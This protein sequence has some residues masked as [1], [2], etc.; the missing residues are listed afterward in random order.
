M[1]QANVDLREIPIPDFGLPK[2]KPQVS[3]AEYESRIEAARR[4]AKADGLAFLVVYGDREHFA[5]L[6]FLTGYDPRF[7]ESL[8]VIPVSGSG[9]PTLVVGNEGDGYAQLQCPGIRRLLYQGFSLLG[10]PRDRSPRLDEVFRSCGIAAGSRVGL[11][12]WK[13][14][15][16]EEAADPAHWLDAPAFIAD[17]LRA[18][19][20]DAA[21]VTN[22]TGIFMNAVDGLRLTSSAGQL[23]AFEFGAAHCSQS[24]RDLIAGLRPGMSELEAV[25]LMHLNGLPLTAHLMFSAGYR[26]RFG[27]PSPSDRVI[28]RGDPFTVAFGLEGGLTCRAGFVAAG[29]SELP[30]ESREY[31]EQMVK[32]YF[33]AAVAWYEAIGVGV[34]GGEVCSAVTAALGGLKLTLNPGHYVHL[35]EWVHTPFFPGS[36]IPLRSGMMLQSDMIPFW[37]PQ[38]H[39]SNIE[40]TIALAD[41]PLRQ[42]IETAHPGTWRRISARRDFVQQVLGI[43]LRPE[44]LPFSNLQCVLQPFALSPGRAM[45]VL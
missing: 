22:A 12:G 4:R 6:A 11:A 41:A 44:V 40:D 17:A 31:V 21:L 23:A 27:L 5:N 35:D 14:A 26:A 18:V 20:G 32:P 34:T 28:E 19:A 45:V 7:E 13:Y 10:Q 16:T 1:H 36:S 39:T 9:E 30:A 29:E 37:H 42:Q 33:R 8:L 2:H 43:R 15:G 24:V 3:T 25:A 38:Y